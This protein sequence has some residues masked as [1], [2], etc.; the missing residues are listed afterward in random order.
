[1]K[2][3]LLYGAYGYTGKL[4]T[5]LAK[6]YG[7]API[8]AGRSEE[9]LQK[10]AAE[11]GF[12]YEAFDLDDTATLHAA[13]AEVEVI[14]HCAGPFANTYERVM[15]ACLATGTH[16]LDITGEID[17]FEPMKKHTQRAQEKGIMLLPGVGFD[18]VPSDCLAA[19]LK[20]AMP[21]ATHLT[22]AI[23][24]KG[25]ISHGT[26][27]SS[28]SRLGQ[29]GKVRVH[30]EL[31]SV[32]HGYKVREFDFDGQ[33]ATGSTIQWGDLSTAFHSTGIPNIETFM[34][35]LPMSIG[36]LKT[37]GY[38]RW[39]IELPFVQRYIQA[40]IKKRPA[41]PSD[42]AREKGY[43]MVWGEVSNANGQSQKGIFKGPEAYTLTAHTSLMAVNKIH[44][45]EFKPGFQTPATAFGKDFILEL[46]DT[47]IK[48]L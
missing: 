10:L 8:L 41:G 45:G 32:P 13:M 40:Q 26:A 43:S 2:K 34:T 18:V 36:T 42:Q 35:N 12:P 27:I 28:A 17:V 7:V 1:M 11:T 29:G 33:K 4:I 20:A 25:G 46:A 24:T 6:N 19:N 9:K 44:A 5:N 39:L 37:I 38:L 48:L 47:E 31:K 16:Y 15:E 30:G 21:D 14:L 22:L 23:L 3:I